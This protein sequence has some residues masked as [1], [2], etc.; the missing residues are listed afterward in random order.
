MQQWFRLICLA[1]GMAFVASFSPVWAQESSLSLDT[2]VSTLGI[3]VSPRRAISDTLTIRLPVSYGSLDG[4][5]EDDDGNT[6]DVNLRSFQ[7]ALMADFH[8]F[9]NGFRLSGGLALG[10]YEARGI[11]QTPTYDGVTIPGETRLRLSQEFP[12][13]PVVS[14]GYQRRSATGFGIFGEIGA[15]YAPYQVSY[16]NSAALTPAQRSELDEAVAEINDD[17]G[18]YSFTPFAALGFS[19]SF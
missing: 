3:T 12:I 6:Y 7:A 13:A 14:L 11:T 10:G 16:S 9:E 2:T 4:E 8:P 5:F 19:F 15:K 1:L 17:V 18:D